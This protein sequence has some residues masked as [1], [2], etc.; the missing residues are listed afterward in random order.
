MT[1]LKSLGLILL[2]AQTLMYLLFIP[3]VKYLNFSK[4]LCQEPH[5]LVGK[6]GGGG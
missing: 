2:N 3:D 1:I 4:N 5:P 6:A